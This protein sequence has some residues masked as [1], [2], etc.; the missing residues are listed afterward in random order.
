MV[1]HSRLKIPVEVDDMDRKL[2]IIMAEDDP[3]NQK[4]TLLMLKKMGLRAEAAANGIEVI[5][6]LEMQT[7]DMVLMDIQMP[8]MDGIETTKIIRE[9]WPHGPKIIVITDCD[10]NI[11]RE[12]CFDAGANEFLSKP[13]I[14]DELTAAIERSESAFSGSL[15]QAV[16]EMPGT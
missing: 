4:V 13:V 14:M 16:S 15:Q 7:Y 11:Y 2:R 12:L 8:E 9:R 6:Y 3:V 10:S 1:N 5:H